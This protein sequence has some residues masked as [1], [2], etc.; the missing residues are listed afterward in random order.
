MKVLHIL[1]QLDTGG[2]ECW[3]NDLIEKSNE[4]DSKIEYTIIVDKV[5]IGNLE[6]NF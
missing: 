4:M 6:Q 1:G 3:L 2:I 5:H